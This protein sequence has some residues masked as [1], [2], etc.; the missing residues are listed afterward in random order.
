MAPPDELRAIAATP[1]E[2]ALAASTRASQVFPKPRASGRAPRLSAVLIWQAPQTR[3]V[4]APWVADRPRHEWPILCG[5]HGCG[6]PADKAPNEPDAC[7][8]N[9]VGAAL[10]LR[11]DAIAELEEIGGG[12]SPSAGEP[13]E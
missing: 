2:T 13:E 3:L 7:A 9:V 5:P 10:E 1:A 4:R 6:H 8:R 11:D 12:V